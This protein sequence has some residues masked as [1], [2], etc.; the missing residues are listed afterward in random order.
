[1]IVTKIAE[2]LNKRAKE[3]DH[4]IAS[5]YKLRSKYLEKERLNPNIFSKQ[6][7]FEKD[8]YA[9]H[10]GGR[11]EMQFNIGLEKYGNKLSTRF[12]LCISLEGGINLKNPVQELDKFRIRFNQLFLLKPELFR[13]FKLW[14]HE[15]NKLKKIV[16]P[17]SI[18][19]SWFKKGNFIALGDFIQKP[20]D[21]LND[22]DFDKILEGFDKLLP[23]YKYC[24]LKMPFDS[25]QCKIAEKRNFKFE[26]GRSKKSIND[27]F[28]KHQKKLVQ[29]KATHNRIQ[30]ALYEKFVE[31]YGG[32]RVGMERGTGLSTRIDISVNSKDGIILYEVKT[33]SSVSYS[34][35]EAIGQLLEYAYYPNPVKNLKEMII[36]TDLPIEPLDAEY[37]K[38]LRK[39]TSL[40]I[41]HQ[42]FNLVN[43][44]L[45][46]KI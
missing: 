44:T 26:F 43:N 18:P 1:M 32:N 10:H 27:R 25:V 4:E 31:E 14:F 13:G 21:K 33:Y 20:F 7:I 46:D 15:N 3:N 24:V 36:V 38:Y 23:I 30:E 39:L 16:N 17:Q 45:S 40:K 9:F 35:R 11:R 34:I 6:T 22:K 42:S 41:F 29:S 28:S 19:I 5:L 2:K 37:L 8:K 12:A